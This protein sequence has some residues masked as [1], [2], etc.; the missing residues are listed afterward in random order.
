MRNSL[1]KKINYLTCGLNLLFILLSFMN[2]YANELKVIPQLNV[3]AYVLMDYHSGKVLTSDNPDER[4]DPA[5]LT[6]IMT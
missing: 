2:V 4:L 3:K 6:K 5:S 1:M